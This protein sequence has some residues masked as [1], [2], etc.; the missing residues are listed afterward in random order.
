MS[1]VTEK[2]LLEEHSYC[3]SGNADE[4]VVDE[5]F[6]VVSIALRVVEV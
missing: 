3:T 2:E 4:C 6:G 1:Y 5:N